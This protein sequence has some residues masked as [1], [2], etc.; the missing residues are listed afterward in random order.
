MAS[1]NDDLT[2]TPEQI[3]N[4]REVRSALNRRAFL[5]GAGALSVAVAGAAVA[6]CGDS[7]TPYVDAAGQAETDVLNFALNLE[8][9]EATFYSYIVTGKDLDGSLT[10]GGPAPTGTPAQPDFLTHY[11]RAILGTI[12]LNDIHFLTLEWVARGP[13]MVERAMVQ[14]RKVLDD[15]LTSPEHRSPARR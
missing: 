7:T 1:P 2:L 10:G 11:L 4:Q 6:G 15:V 8:Y 9:L 12:G 5:A 14:A 3:A 13:A